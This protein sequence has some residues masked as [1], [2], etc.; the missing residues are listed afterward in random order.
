MK[1]VLVILGLLM[2][3][4]CT[5]MPINSSPAKQEEVFNLSF[6]DVWKQVVEVLSDENY[7]IESIEKDSGLITTE[8]ISTGGDQIQRIARLEKGMFFAW[9][10]GSYK[11]NIF[12]VSIDDSHT[13]VKINPY[14]K[15][16][17]YILESWK[18]RASSTGLI[19]RSIF[20]RIKDA[21]PDSNDPID[22]PHETGD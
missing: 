22:I 13:R 4:G 3:S 11:L 1:R 7:P 15:A 19:E 18:Q 9:T 10:T 20:R 2:L 21:E 12:V 8:F 6:D 14:I 5:T 16:Y 17:N